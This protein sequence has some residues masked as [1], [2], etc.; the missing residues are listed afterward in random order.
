[1]PLP[2]RFDGVS[3]NTQYAGKEKITFPESSFA[4]YGG[5]G[6]NFL[7]KMNISSSNT[8]TFDMEAVL[9][10]NYQR[11]VYRDRFCRE[12]GTRTE[13]YIMPPE[14]IKKHSKPLKSARK[15]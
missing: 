14:Q 8:L 6:V 12:E 9:E 3:V 11:E 7:F 4:K 10:E 15:W 1:M 13:N 5:M 2:K